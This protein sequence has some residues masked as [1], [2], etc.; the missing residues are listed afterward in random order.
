MMP[1]FDA[2]FNKRAYMLMFASSNI[3][4]EH[5]Y[6]YNGPLSSGYGV[7]SIDGIVYKVH[8]LSAAIFHNLDLNDETQ[9]VNHKVGCPNRNCWCP[10]HIYVG[11]QKQNME[12]KQQ[13]DKAVT[14]LW[15][16][17]LNQTKRTHCPKG[18]EY[19][20]ENTRIQAGTNKRQCRE[21]A[22]LSK[23]GGKPRSHTRHSNTKI[24]KE[25]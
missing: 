8:R 17:A 25:N 12:D 18:H 14:G 1:I 2:E 7:I 11:T 24:R 15:G 10:D 22:R 5:C 6:V 23:S 3:S 4:D 21:C 20:P 13:T 9:Q 16:N 19:T